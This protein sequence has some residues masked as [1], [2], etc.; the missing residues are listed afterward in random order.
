MSRLA[1]GL[2]RVLELCAIFLFG[3]LCL[4]VFGEVV[5]RYLLNRP[6]FGSEEVIIYL[7]TWVAF[8]GSCL[9]L[10]SDRHVAISYFVS[11][12]P[13]RVQVLVGIAGDG[14]V[15]AFLGLLVVQGVR[16]T[17]MNHTVSSITLQ[18]PLSCVAASLLVM[19]VIMILFQMTRLADKISRARSGGAGLSVETPSA[20]EKAV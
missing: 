1:A 13:G 10:R 17:R 2:A 19:A 11:L 15:L 16:F 8:L 12:L 20:T 7:F 6:H 18:I 3:L 4:V 9:A 14:I 5:S